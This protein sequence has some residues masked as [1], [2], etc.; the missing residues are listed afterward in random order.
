MEE[1]GPCP[2]FPS[3]TLAFALQLRKN[4]GKTSIRVS[5]NLSQIKNNLQS[6][7]SIHIAKITLPLQSPHQ[8]THYKTHSYTHYNSTLNVTSERNFNVL[9]K[10]FIFYILSLLEKTG[11]FKLSSSSNPKFIPP[12][13]FSTSELKIRSKV[14]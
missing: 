9:L 8:H 13:T 12:E 14:S 7:Y 4:H 11:S 3:Y 6:Q 1:C 5:I 2:V 10:A